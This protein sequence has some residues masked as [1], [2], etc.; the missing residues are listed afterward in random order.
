MVV[1]G[2][3][4]FTSHAMAALIFPISGRVREGRSEAS[5]RGVSCFVQVWL[6]IGGVGVG[7]CW[8]GCVLVWL[9]LGWVWWK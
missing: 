7:V 1:L 9:E 4:M 2:E 8:C 5:G 6:C 3:L